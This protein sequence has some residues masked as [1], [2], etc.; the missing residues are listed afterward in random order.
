MDHS[1]VKTARSPRMSLMS[2]PVQWIT[3]LTLLCI[4]CGG[5]LAG[6]YWLEIGFQ[7]LL[8]LVMAE[9]WNLQAGYTGLVSLGTAA[10]VG[11]GGYALVGL[12]NH[13]GLPI[14]FAL[15]AAGLAA[16]VMALSVSKAVFRMRGLYFTVGTLAMAEALRLF[17]INSDWFGGAT[18]LFLA[19]D[20][21]SLR[22][23]FWAAFAV[24]IATVT[25]TYFATAGRV[26]VL[27]RAI[28]DDEDAAAQVGVRAFRVKLGVF[29]VSSFLIGVAGGLQALKLG[30]I[31]PYG[32]FGMQWTVTV[33]TVVII[34]GQGTRLGP[35]LGALLMVGLSELLA[36][37]PAIHLALMGML[38]ILIIRFSPQ[39]LAG[40]IVPRNQVGGRL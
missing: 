31:E 18:G 16:L 2:R 8:L 3:P 4:A 37:Y 32:M 30:V 1:I 14:A 12:V 23:L 5:S 35:L 9:A 28:R 22:V 11:V 34:G 13:Y 20:S 26:S 6:N 29:A 21:P 7:L 39:G 19:E 40:F 10:F 36:D 27:L 15:P 38:L 24:L 33:L 17:M 25:I